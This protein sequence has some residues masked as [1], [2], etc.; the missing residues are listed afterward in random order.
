LLNLRVA[1]DQV[2][3]VLREIPPER[4]ELVEVTQECIALRDA[5]IRAKVVGRS[6]VEDAEHIAIASVCGAD[7][8]VSWN[9]RHVVH[10]DKIAGY[11]AVNLANGYNTVRIHS[12]REVV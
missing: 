2:R 4:V 12:P 6:S 5:Y 10:Y 8:V 7:M 11:N 3:S 1:P 9:F